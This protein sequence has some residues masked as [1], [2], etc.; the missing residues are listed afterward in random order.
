VLNHPIF[1]KQKLLNGIFNLGPVPVGGD[2]NTGSQHGCRPTGPTHPPHNIA[3]LRAVFDPADWANC[4]FVLAGGQSGNPVSPHYD[5]LFALWWKGDGVPIAWS[6][7]EVLRAAVAAVRLTPAPDPR[8]FA[9]A[10]GP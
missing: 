4:R 7:A 9:E 2:Q 10:S 8:R 5:D 6:P 3:G 1:G